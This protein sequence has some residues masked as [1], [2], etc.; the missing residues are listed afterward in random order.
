MAV[1]IKI[2]HGDGSEEDPKKENKEVKPEPIQHEP[3][4]EAK[5]F[6]KKVVSYGRALK[7]RGLY[8]NMADE[9][10]IQKRELS[11]HGDAKQ[12]LEP[13][14][15]RKNSKKFAGRYICGGCG[16]GDKSRNFLN[17]DGYIKLYYP[18]VTCPIQMPGFINETPAKPHENRK[19]RVEI[20]IEQGYNK[21]AN[22]NNKESK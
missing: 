17:G 13:C 1:N 11:C 10:T 15:L 8:D 21:Q 22:D 16:C 2:H 6:I 14:H 5:S 19:K 9:E 20:Q 12:G 4:P 3:T 18:D 7:S